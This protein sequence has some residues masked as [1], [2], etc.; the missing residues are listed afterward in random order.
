MYGSV[1]S[2]I[3]QEQNVGAQK[4]KT[5]Q[6]IKNEWLYAGI[7]MSDWARE[8]GHNKATVSQVL[9]GRNTA[10]R[11]VGH[12]IAVQLGIKDGVIGREIA[13]Q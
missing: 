1:W 13:Q 5:P 11:G 12:M 9:T 2:R 6:D 3:Q 4:L 8:H 7:T 10:S